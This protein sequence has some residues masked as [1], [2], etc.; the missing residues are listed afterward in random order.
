[1]S[2]KDCDGLIGLLK[3][4]AI[5]FCDSLEEYVD[6]HSA[7]LESKKEYIGQIIAA[8]VE[9]MR[10]NKKF[11]QRVREWP[12]R[13][14]MDRDLI[15]QQKRKFSFSYRIDDLLVGNVTYQLDKKYKHKEL[16]P[17][18]GD[19]VVSINSFNSKA[20]EYISLSLENNGHKI[21]AFTYASY[22]IRASA[23][24]WHRLINTQVGDKVSVKVSAP[25]ETAP[26][27]AALYNV[28]N[29]SFTARM[30][31]YDLNYDASL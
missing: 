10:R 31:K 5:I 11:W 29:H 18:V 3:G 15:A 12:H 21:I 4:D 22:S 19:E 23:P 24:L 1:M 20:I 14:S 6:N 8:N 26:P 27:M 30:K 16:L 28:Y 7:L 13:K 25:H 9:A 17:P 2:D